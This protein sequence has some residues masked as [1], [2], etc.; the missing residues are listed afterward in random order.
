MRPHDETAGER[1]R[2][3]SDA[4]ES[5][6]WVVDRDD[7]EPWGVWFHIALAAVL[8]LLLVIVVRTF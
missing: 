2:E 8:L 1:A 7:P 5:R 3:T 6:R 4:S